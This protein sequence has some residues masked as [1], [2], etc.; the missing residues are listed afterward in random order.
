MKKT[1]CFLIMSILTFSC[2]EKKKEVNPNLIYFNSEFLAELDDVNYD[3]LKANLNSKVKAK[4][5]DKIIYISKK[6]D[7]NAC[8]TYSG[9]LEIKK[10]SII[11]IYRLTSDEVC[12]STAIVE[13]TYIIKN[14]KKKRYSFGIRYE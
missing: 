3:K 9:D 7:A 5:I 10:D 11:L 6:I 2:A 14:P 12:T 1:Y 4:Y 13:A 8:G